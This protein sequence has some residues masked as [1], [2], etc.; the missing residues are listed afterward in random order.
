MGLII[1]FNKML[2]KLKIDHRMNPKLFSDHI[3]SGQEVQQEQCKGKTVLEMLNANHQRQSLPN[4][5]KVEI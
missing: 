4:L 3:K 1:D 5:S 2:D